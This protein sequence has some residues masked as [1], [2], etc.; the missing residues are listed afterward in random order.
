MDYMSRGEEII[1][2]H[3]YSKEKVEGKKRVCKMGIEI[4]S[5]RACLME[6]LCHYEKMCE[7]NKVW[8]GGSLGP[9]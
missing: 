5:C 9:E 7:E 4:E 2:E 1:K 6:A 8:R 3:F